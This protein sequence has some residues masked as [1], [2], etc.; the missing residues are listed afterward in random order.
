MGTPLFFPGILE[1]FS[2]HNSFDIGN[3]LIRFASAD[4]LEDQQKSY[5]LIRDPKYKD[6]SFMDLRPYIKNTKWPEKHLVI[7]TCTGGRETPII[8]LSWI[9]QY[10]ME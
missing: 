5:S 8:F 1:R 10:R 9:Y 2:S 7:A 4:R 3:Q 6:I